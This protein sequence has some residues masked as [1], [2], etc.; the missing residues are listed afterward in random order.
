MNQAPVNLM[1]AT[2]RCC[3]VGAL[4]TIGPFRPSDPTRILRRT[5]T[6]MTTPMFDTLSARLDGLEAENHRLS[7]EAR[8]LRLALIAVLLV[9]A[10]CAIA[11]ASLAD[12]V[13][14]VRTER[15]VLVDKLG[16]PRVELNVD[17]QGRAALGFLD[18]DQKPR[19]SLAMRPAGNPTIEL[20]DQLGNARLSFSVDAFG[21]PSA[22]FADQ[23]GKTRLLAR[24]APSGAPEISAQAKDGS[25]RLFAGMRADGRPVFD[26]RDKAGKVRT[27]SMRSTPTT[28]R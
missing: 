25:V 13:P 22:S 27:R 6:T 18:K 26:L 17:A 15:L 16:Q 19:L 14:E 8:R 2:A 1:M 23:D 10:G 4:V 20:M 7:R 28:C 5:D 3:A 21:L 12:H 11:G 9:A 24:V